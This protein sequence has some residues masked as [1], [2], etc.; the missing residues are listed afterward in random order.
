MKHVCVLP[1]VSFHPSIRSVYTK[2]STILTREI[3]EDESIY[4]VA[5]S[6]IHDNFEI[7]GTFSETIHYLGQ[8]TCDGILYECI[9][10]NLTNDDYT[11]SLQQLEF[12]RIVRSETGHTDALLLSLCFKAVSFFKITI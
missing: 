1:F 8:L 5:S 2:G 4:D 6:I 12:N 10:V 3:E 9:A 11:T 7:V